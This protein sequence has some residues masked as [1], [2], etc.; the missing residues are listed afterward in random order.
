MVRTGS[1][2]INGHA[3][4]VEVLPVATVADPTADAQ[5][6]VEELPARDGRIVVTLPDGTVLTLIGVPRLVIAADWI[7][8]GA[9]RP[10]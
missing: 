8:T 5:G 4:N 10:L 2:P 7:G 1:R 6:L 9:P 3:S